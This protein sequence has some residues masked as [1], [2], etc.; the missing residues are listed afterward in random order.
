[1]N[2]IWVYGKDDQNLRERLMGMEFDRAIL[3]EMAQR[4]FGIRA[5]VLSRTRAADTIEQNRHIAQQEALAAK[6][7]LETVVENANSLQQLKAKIADLATDLECHSYSQFSEQMYRE[8]RKR[9]R[10]LSAV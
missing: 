5:H 7:A 1:M 2:T 9:L 6:Q 4:D 10:Q 8:L 3:S